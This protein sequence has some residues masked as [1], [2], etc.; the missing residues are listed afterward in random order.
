M[1]P[2]VRESEYIDVNAPDF[3]VQSEAP[4][5]KVDNSAVDQSKEQLKQIWERIYTFLAAL[6]EY[7]AE[8]FGEYRRPLVTLGLIFASIVSVKMTLALL[9]AINDIPL[10]APT[11]ELIGLSYTAWFI[12][13]YLWKASSREELTR[14]F[15]AFKD[16]VLGGKGAPKP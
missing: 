6:P 8:F 2:E 13:R 15:S 9:D 12:Y 16:E 4:L 14:D 11:F 10:L 5:V 7:L 3:T 1:N